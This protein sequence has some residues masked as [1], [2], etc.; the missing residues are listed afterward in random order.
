VATV[1]GVV[2]QIA[3]LPA[4][5][6]TN[7]VWADDGSGFLGPAL[8]HGWGAFA[9]PYGGYLVSITRVM[10]AVAATL[11]LRL[12]ALVLGAGSALVV[13]LVAGL[14]YLSM[15]GHIPSRGLRFA[16]AAMMVLIPAVGMEID[17][18]AANLHWYL[19]FAAVWI[20][21]ARPPG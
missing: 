5:V 6:A 10:A 16:F 20:L 17:P 19:V 8:Q 1:F 3:R 13:C 9:F 18:N 7:T 14:V 15:R 12:A 21:L 11:P 2:L 4:G